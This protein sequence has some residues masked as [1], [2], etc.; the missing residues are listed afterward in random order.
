LRCK[1]AIIACGDAMGEGGMMTVRE[2]LERRA[3]DFATTG[4]RFPFPILLAALTTAG[5]LWATVLAVI[6]LVRRGDI[7][8]VPMLAGAILLLL[9]IGPWNFINL[10]VA[11]QSARLA[12][13]LAEPGTDGAGFPPAW[14]A[15]QVADARSAVDFLR[16]D[17]DGRRRLARM[18]APYG[19]TVPTDTRSP[20]ASSWRRWAIRTRGRHG[21]PR[22][23]CSAPAVTGST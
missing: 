1:S 14:S 7:R 8:L 4:R 16:G 18:F 15:E 5:G 12:A 11:Q 20:A 21:S 9:S 3:P 17:E 22:A 10:P 23:P 19:I 13:L 6:F 2:W